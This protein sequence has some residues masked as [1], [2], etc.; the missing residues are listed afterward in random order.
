MATGLDSLTQEVAAMGGA[1]DSAVT[2]IVGFEAKLN[3]IIAAGNNDPALVQFASDLAAQRQR[4]AD[5][6][7]ANPIPV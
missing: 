7:A 2:L 3:E 1:I 6:V 4:L 5:A